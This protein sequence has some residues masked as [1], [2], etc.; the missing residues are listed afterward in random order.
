MIVVKLEMWPYGDESRKYDLGR[1][2]IANV[3]GDAERGEYDA[4]VCRRGTTA[5]PSPVDPDG[6][7]PT[8]SSHVSNYPRLAYNVW[9]L[10]IRA[11]LGAFP[12]EAA[13]VRHASPEDG[14]G[15][16]ILLTRI[17]ALEAQNAELRARLGEP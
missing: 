7:K 8:R 12:E 10:I 17:D 11:L 9:R 4:A 1:T 2:Y 5:V 3:G 15:R 13:R 16:E 14:E 6:P